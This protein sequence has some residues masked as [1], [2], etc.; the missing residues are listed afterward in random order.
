MEQ[1]GAI[2][3]QLKDESQSPK[4]TGLCHNKQ[5]QIL[6]GCSE[7]RCDIVLKAWSD[8]VTFASVFNGNLGAKLM[9]NPYYAYEG[10]S[11][12]GVNV[13][14]LYEFNE[15]YKKEVEEN[16]LIRITEPGKGWLIAQLNNLFMTSASKDVES[17]NSIQSFASVFY[18]R[19]MRYKI[20]EL[21]LFFARYKAGMYDDGSWSQFST[22]TIG[23]AFG[24]FQIDRN[25]ELDKIISSE[26]GFRY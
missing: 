16:G 5:P 11:N 26:K 20:T 18:A 21:L 17:Y 14:T 25:H 1:I 15:I 3:K 8:A 6:R 19:V 22:Q 12:K 24:K 13:P 4:Q 9:E 2:L 7:K 10:V 23:R